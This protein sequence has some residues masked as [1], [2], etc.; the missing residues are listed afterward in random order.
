MSAR[1]D[2]RDWERLFR[3]GAPRRGGPLQ[4]LANI[5]I[6]GV[7]LGAVGGGAWLA[8]Q[9][10]IEQRNATA[11]A[12][13]VQAATSNAA[14]FAT[15]TARALNATA[16]ATAPPA[17]TPLAAP[18][19][20]GSVIVAGNL[21]SETLLSPETVRG[22]LCIGDEVAFLE[23]QNVDAALWYRIRVTKLAAECS[24]QRAPVGAEG[25][26]NSTLLSPP[27]R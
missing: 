16:A 27:A 4:V 25:W 12:Q 1:I 7:V 19:G 14:T 11:T 3:P 26:A 21:R 10:G 17:A 5:L 24:P 22:Q 20:V 18:L 8:L 2:P 23:E 9:Y 6:V 13:A 15:R